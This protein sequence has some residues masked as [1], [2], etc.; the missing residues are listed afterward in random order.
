[1]L[2]NFLI[3]N[4]FPDALSPLSRLPFLIFQLFNWF[5]WLNAFL[6]PTQQWN[7]LKNGGARSIIINYNCRTALAKCNAEKT[8]KITWKLLKNCGKFNLQSENDF[9]QLWAFKNINTI[10]QYA[11]QQIL[12]TTKNVCSFRENIFRLPGIGKILFDKQ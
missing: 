1:M 5:N 4:N 2:W 10:A 9:S 3:T 12:I 7:E 8:V 11:V 6:E